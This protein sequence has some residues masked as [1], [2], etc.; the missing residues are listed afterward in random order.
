VR[1][2]FSYTHYDE[3]KQYNP[4]FPVRLGVLSSVCEFSFFAL[5][6]WILSDSRGRQRVGCCCCSVTVP[7][8]HNDK[9]NFNS[10]MLFQVQ[11]KFGFDIHLGRRT[12]GPIVDCWILLGILI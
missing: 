7:D 8:F 6:F 10:I 11:H 9:V 5:S 2:G 3:I 12:S 1:V 4:I